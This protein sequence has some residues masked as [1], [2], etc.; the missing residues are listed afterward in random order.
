LQDQYTP[1]QPD[2]KSE[3]EADKPSARVSPENQVAAVVRSLF[4]RKQA[5]EFIKLAAVYPDPRKS[6]SRAF[7]CDTLPGLA[8]FADRHAAAS[9]LGNAASY[10]KLPSGQY[11][12]YRLHAVFVVINY[13][14]AEEE[15]EAR[16]RLE[17]FALQPRAL[18][19]TRGVLCAWWALRDPINLTNDDQA[20]RACLL[21]HSLAE[22]LGGNHAAATP[23]RL[24]RVP[25]IKQVDGTAIGPYAVE[26][27]IRVLADASQP[28]PGVTDGGQARYDLDEIAR[29]L[30][31]FHRS[32]YFEIR[33]LG[34]AKGIVAGIYSADSAEEIENAAKAAA[35]LSGHCKGVYF[36]IN[37]IKR[38]VAEDQSRRVA[39]GKGLIFGLESGEGIADTDIAER[40]W[41]PID[42]DRVKPKGEAD[43]SASAVEHQAALQRT[44]EIDAYL[45]KCGISSQ[46]LGDS[47]NGGHACIPIEALPA[48]SNLIHRLLQTMDRC[49]S[50]DAV[51][52]DTTVA[53]AARIWKLYGTR[54]C[55]GADSPDR[56]HRT[57]RLLHVPDQPFALA[58]HE[59][60]EAIINA[61]QPEE[62]ATKAKKKPQTA[63][64]PITWTDI[65]PYIE[66]RITKQKEHSDGMLLVEIEGCPFGPDHGEDRAGYITIFDNGNVVVPGCHHDHCQGQG[67]L[68]FLKAAAP[69]L[70]G[71]LSKPTAEQFK[72]WFTPSRDGGGDGTRLR[73]SDERLAE[74]HQAISARH[75]PGWR[76]SIVEW[77]ISEYAFENHWAQDLAGHPTYMIMG[78]T[79][80]APKNASANAPSALSPK[81]P[82]RP[83]W[84]MKPSRASPRTRRS[85][86]NGR[87]SAC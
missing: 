28:E 3:S 51:K 78:F 82:G 20:E 14:T 6:D 71:K 50:D 41:I 21:L 65:L 63:A 29:T 55:K 36:T 35:S 22:R 85:C 79:G 23:D 39:Y 47:G 34:H 27:F 57:A 64:N 2:K 18:T 74:V 80:S 86:G 11:E 25:P 54:A 53:N 8:A 37:P 60:L 87:R 76:A 32:G 1:D 13:K 15:A 69:E 24:L 17:A 48:N 77:L 73:I 58:T 9:L 49:F 38:E 40:N 10:R 66:A 30:Q 62:K 4:G 5:L 12:V 68:D 26:D 31:L 45:G 75:G 61:N 52:I 67:F 56:P 84:S 59:M 19:R 83:S 16:R 70:I 46:I 81:M 44:C 7:F 43:H 42:C 72:R 33:A